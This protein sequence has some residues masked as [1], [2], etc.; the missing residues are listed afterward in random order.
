[1]TIRVFPRSVA[2]T[3]TAN[4]RSYSVAP[5][6]FA[7]VPDHDATILLANGFISAG[8]VGATAARPATAMAGATFLDTTVGAV[9][10]SDGA[11]TW[12]NVATGAVA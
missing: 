11:G 12:R 3:G 9:V 6:S 2:K 8:P 5:G 10:I 4:G 1:M 7:D